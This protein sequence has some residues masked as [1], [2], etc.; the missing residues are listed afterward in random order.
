MPA[1]ETD[2]V[3]VECLVTAGLPAKDVRDWLQAEPGETT[4]FPAD[5]RKFSAY[6]QKGS[7]LLGRL[8]PKPRRNE[9]EGAA[10]RTIQDRAREARAQFLRR[11]GDA[12]YDA[13][14]VR[15]SRFVRVED[16]VIRAAGV[17]PGL[18]PTAQ[19]I[20]AEDG[21][22]QRDK[23]GQEI[24]QGLFLSAV[25]GASAPD[26][27]SAMRCCCRGRMPRRCCRNSCATAW[28]SLTARRCGA[29]ARR[30]RDAEQSA[31]SQ[32]GGPDLAR[33]RG[34]LRRPGA[35]RSGDRDRGHARR[36]GRAS[37][38]PRAPRVRRRHQ[39]HPSLSWPHPVRLVSAARSR[40]REQGLSR[41]R[42]SRRRAARRIRRPDQREAVDCRG[43]SVCHRRPLPGL[44]G[45]GLCARRD[46]PR[47]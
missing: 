32:R 6:W 39:S 45:D 44:A 23:S 37:E 27:I 2:P 42:F 18:V 10:A 33:W 16:L 24:D 28:S 9:G 21:C 34:N 11:H 13:L 12:V 15:R 43:R 4:D 47:S 36:G 8:P 31:L 14:T 1:R 40:L 19:E 26:A 41:A 35:A 30:G 20:A 38:I 3:A 29:S 46:A 17:V 5:R 22:I 25:L 7:R